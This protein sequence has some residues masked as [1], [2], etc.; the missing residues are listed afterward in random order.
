[1]ALL[2]ASPVLGFVVS[3]LLLYDLPGVYYPY[4]VKHFLY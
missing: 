4:A 2:P 1:M 3:L